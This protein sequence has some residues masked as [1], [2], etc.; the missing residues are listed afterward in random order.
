[1]LCKEAV[2]DDTRLG[3]AASLL[4]YL[5]SRFLTSCYL[6]YKQWSCRPRYSDGKWLWVWL[7]NP[8]YST[9]QEAWAQYLGWH[10]LL[11]SYIV[12]CVK[13][14]LDRVQSPFD[15]FRTVEFMGLMD[16]WSLEE[17]WFDSTPFHWASFSFWCHWNEKKCVVVW[18]YC[19]YSMNHNSNHNILTISFKTCLSIT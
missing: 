11:Y 8:C 3:L 9:H 12:G 10:D 16:S 4:F 7:T 6:I 17:S 1:M 19:H 2:K 18:L 5:H 14:R 15:Y 13:K